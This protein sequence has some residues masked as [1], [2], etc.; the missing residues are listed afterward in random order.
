MPFHFATHNHYLDVW[1]ELGI[2][3]VSALVFILGYVIVTARRALTAPN[4]ELRPHLIACVFGIL[5]LAIDLMFGNMMN[6]WPYI[7]IYVGVCMRA[8]LLTVEPAQQ[9]VADARTAPLAT[10]PPPRFRRQ[11]T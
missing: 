2:P 5:S 6:P 11:P 3:G 9:P 8:A 7:W 10:V 1:F 4:A